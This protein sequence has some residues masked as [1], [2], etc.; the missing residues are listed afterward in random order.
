MN[1]M[2]P[3]IGTWVLILF[4]MFFCYYLEGFHF[5]F[6]YHTLVPS[7]R[8]L[9]ISLLISM[10]NGNA[11]ALFFHPAF[12]QK[13]ESRDRD[14]S[15]HVSIILPTHSPYRKYSP[16]PRVGVDDNLTSIQAKTI[17]VLV[18]V[19]SVYLHWHRVDEIWENA[20]KP[21]WRSLDALVLTF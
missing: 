2:Q 4:G 9:P 3:F 13:C 6:P 5:W 14:V 1:N 20:K 11:P 18:P 15:G 17:L 19:R 10:Q 7:F 8:E 12:I 21:R 16:I